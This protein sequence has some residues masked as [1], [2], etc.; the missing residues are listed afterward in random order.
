M[1]GGQITEK[2]IT[3]NRRGETQ[4]FIVLDDK[5]GRI[6]ISIFSDLFRNIAKKSTKIILFL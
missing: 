1:I 3:K 6:E 4:A 2:R 5:T